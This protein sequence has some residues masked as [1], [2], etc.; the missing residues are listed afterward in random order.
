MKA[1]TL[2]G[3]VFPVCLFLVPAVASADAGIGA[4]MGW[5]KAKDAEDG[6]GFVGGHLELRLLPWLGVQGAAD[7][8]LVETLRVDTGAGPD[9]KLDV[10][11]VPLTATGRIYIPLGQVEPFAAAGAGWYH[12]I[13]DFSQEVEDLG[14][15]DDSETTFGWH[16][17]AGLQL[18]VSPRFSLFGEGRAVFVDPDRRLDEDLFD[19]V[20]EFD[21]DSTFFFGGATLHF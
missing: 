7:Y 19:R 20:E 14:I 13:Y 8:R 1:K 21:H 4:H 16:V 2:A 9:G 10:R 3:I 15:E 11:S 5:A 18:R 17:G 12:I 6:N